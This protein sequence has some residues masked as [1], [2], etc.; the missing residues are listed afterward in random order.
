MRNARRRH[1]GPTSASTPGHSLRRAPDALAVEV[2]DLAIYEH[3]LEAGIL[4]RG[5]Q[6]VAG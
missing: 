6:E 5:V 1:A 2:R 3:L 4:G